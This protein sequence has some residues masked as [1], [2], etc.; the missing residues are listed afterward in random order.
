VG[1][2][3]YDYL[4][5]EPLIP[6][7]HGI[8]YSPVEFSNLKLSSKNRKNGQPISVTFEVENKGELETV[9]IPQLYVKDVESSL[10]RPPKELK[11]FDRVRLKPGET[12]TVTLELDDSSFAFYDPAK[13]AWVVESGAF[14]ILIGA[15]SRNILLS[16]TLM[17]K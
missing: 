7:G 4:N 3:W 2:R 15:S 14:E 10:P 9:A 11:G 1:Y 6:F 17:Q 12:K 13:N 5:I 8:S 16:E